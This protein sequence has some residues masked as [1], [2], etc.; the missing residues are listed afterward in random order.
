M[1]KDAARSARAIGDRAAEAIALTNLGSCEWHSSRDDAAR[2][3]RQALELHCESR[4]AA[5][6]ARVLGNLGLVALRNG[7]CWQCVAAFR[8]ARELYRQGG[9]RVGEAKTLMHLG[10]A[11]FEQG[12]D[13]RDLPR[14]LASAHQKHACRPTSVWPYSTRADTPRRR[15]R[16]AERGVSGDGR[17]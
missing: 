3:L 12:S 4:N 13:A 9:S 8:R 7:R 2:H 15:P 11:A 6:Q 10:V 1:C 14:K 17:A 16:S 5:G